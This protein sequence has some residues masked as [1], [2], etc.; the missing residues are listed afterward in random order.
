LVASNIALSAY[1]DL[2]ASVI[3]A[4][5]PAKGDDAAADQGGGA[6]KDAA[7]PKTGDDF[8][9]AVTLRKAVLNVA[10]ALSSLVLVAM[11]LPAFAGLT[12]EIEMAGKTHADAD[13]RAD[14]EPSPREITLAVGPFRWPAK[15]VDKPSPDPPKNFVAGYKTVTDWKTNHGLALEFSDV[16]TAMAAAAAP[17]LSNGVFDVA[18]SIFGVP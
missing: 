14:P 6:K 2:G 8:A 10:G 17:L 16:A 18:K 1:A 4:L 11:F 12:G 3:E 7:G 13:M 9:K 15:A 5:Q